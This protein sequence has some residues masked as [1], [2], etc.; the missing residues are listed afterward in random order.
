MQR[1]SSGPDPGGGLAGGKQWW[2][3]WPSPARRTPSRRNWGF[4]DVRSFGPRPIDDGLWRFEKK[5][6]EFS[7]YYSRYGCEGEFRL[8]APGIS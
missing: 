6:I 4:R 2:R 7:E 8:V 5:P 1:H 3:P